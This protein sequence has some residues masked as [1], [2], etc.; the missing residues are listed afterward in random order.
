MAWVLVFGAML[1]FAAA[2]FGVQYLL[3]PSPIGLSSFNALHFEINYLD[4]GF[5]RRALV[6]TL[7]QA[8]PE[9]ART[10]AILVFGWA[11]IAALAALVTAVL[12]VLHS[13]MS[14][15]SLRLLAMLW[16]A[17]PWTFLN[18]GYDFARLDQ[19]NLLLLALSLWL[20]YRN[21]VIWLALVSVFGLLIHEAYLFYGLTPVLAYGWVR[22]RAASATTACRRLA[23]P[24]AA[25]LTTLATIALIGRYEPGRARLIESLKPRLADPNHN[26][27]NVWLRSG[28]ENPEYV[29]A[30]LGHGLFGALELVAMA[31]MV[32]VTAAALV[33][34]SYANDR[35]PDP[36][37]LSP[38][39]VVPLFCFGIDYARWAG[40]IA[41]LALVVVTTRLLDGKFYVQHGRHSAY[42]YGGLCLALLAGPLGTVHALPLWG[43]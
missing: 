28:L 15:D 21:R 9:A 20:V 37:L 32:L 3:S 11:V 16:I 8:V 23:L 31:G 42:L 6:G 34:L 40:L 24:I 25:A 33:G 14:G 12:H 39:A 2:G 18:F 10:N 17:A 7:F 4:H 1:V 36:F 29:V 41:I 38:L 30:R 13:R 27:L 26:A 19:L 5:V 22:Y 43:P 35:R